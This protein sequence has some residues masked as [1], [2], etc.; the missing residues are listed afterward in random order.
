MK[1][2]C[3]GV[4]HF[5]DEALN[6]EP[7]RLDVRE[8][9]GVAEIAPPNQASCGSVG[10][11][12]AA[13]RPLRSPIG[14]FL[15]ANADAGTLRI[16]I[17]VIILVLGLITLFNIQ[18]PMV[19]ST[20][21][22]GVVGFLTSLSITT[23]SIGGPL[24]AIY[25]VAQQ[26]PA[27]KIRTTLAFYFVLSYL[28]GFVFYAWAGL[29]HRETLVNIAILLPALVAGLQ[30]GDVLLAVNGV[31]FGSEDEEAWQAVKSEM[32]VG[33]TITYAVGRDG[34]KKKVRVTLA[35]VPDE[36]MARWVGQHMLEHTTIELA[37]NR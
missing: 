29:L 12:S 28:V 27:Q 8:L 32:Q 21:T 11:S 20:A 5:I 4:S 26:W 25:A 35:Q 30:E 22:G 15:L 17:G 36:V 18:L 13:E 6:P 31:K 34:H 10:K 23:L 7:K 2:L 19:R 24:V 16:A 37:Q 3:I 9:T 33:N 14:V 1:E